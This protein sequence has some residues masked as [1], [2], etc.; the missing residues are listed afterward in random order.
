MSKL[1]PIDDA[2]RRRAIA[3]VADASN[4]GNPMAGQTEETQSAIAETCLRR[5]RSLG[6]RGVSADDRAGQIGDLTEG[7]IGQHFGRDRK[8]LGPRIGY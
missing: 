3:A 5:F 7:L 8:M 4:S 6:R 1:K 2:V